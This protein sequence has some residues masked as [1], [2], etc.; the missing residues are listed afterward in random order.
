M[1]ASGCCLSAPD[2]RAGGRQQWFPLSLPFTSLQG[3]G[4]G[5]SSPSRDRDKSLGKPSVTELSMDQTV[6]QAALL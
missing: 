5:A 3:E 4:L 1:V 6:P 2:S